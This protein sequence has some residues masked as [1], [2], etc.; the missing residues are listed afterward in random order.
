MASSL[1]FRDQELIDRL[2]VQID[3]AIGSHS[4]HIHLEL[5]HIDGGGSGLI[6]LI[7]VT[8]TATVECLLL[9]L[10]GQHTEGEWEVTQKPTCVA[11][12]TMQTKC[13]GCGTVIRTEKV[14]VSGEH[15]LG[16]WQTVEEPTCSKDG[17]KA[18]YCIHCNEPQEIDSLPAAHKP[19]DW[20]VIEEATCTAE[21]KRGKYCTGC[22]T[23]VISTPT[24]KK[25]H[26]FNGGS[27]CSICGYAPESAT[28]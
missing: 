27:S 15:T 4:V 5:H 7:A 14:P 17:V 13:T 26:S 3:G 22:N 8:A 19:G 16:D 20:Q 18:R 2:G 12:G 23:L 28:E 11:E 9:V 24:D 10:N 6:A 1:S 21:G 25:P